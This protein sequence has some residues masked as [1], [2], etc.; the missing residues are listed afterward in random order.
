LLQ[1]KI[2]N[3]L[4]TITLK[5]LCTTHAILL[6]TL[7]LPKSKEKHKQWVGEEQ[8]MF[9]WNCI[10]EMVQCLFTIKRLYYPCV[11]IKSRDNLLHYMDHSKKQV[12]FKIPWK[13]TVFFFA[14]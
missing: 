7:Y 4:I 12:R 11:S 9:L 8:N 1:V 5:A 13:R 10:Q 3:N 6:N 14:A 2:L